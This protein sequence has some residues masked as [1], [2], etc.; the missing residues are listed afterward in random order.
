MFKIRSLISDV[1]M[2]QT[3]SEFPFI[4]ESDK[5]NEIDA[6]LVDTHFLQTMKTQRKRSDLPTDKPVFLVIDKNQSLPDGDTISIKPDSVL[7]LPFT[8]NELK[9]LIQLFN[10]NKVE[11]KTTESCEKST[12]S[13]TGHVSENTPKEMDSSMDYRMLLDNSTVGIYRTTPDGRVLYAN[14]TLIRMLGYSSFQE[15]AQIDINKKY[16]PKYDRKKFIDIIE[17]KGQIVGL[18]EAWERSDGSIIHVRESAKAVRDETGRIL[19]YDGVVEDIT[20]LKSVEKSLSE[21]EE[22][23]GKIFEL[24]PDPIT[25]S[26]IED[27]IFI[28]VNERFCTLT[29]YSKEEVIGRSS[30][31]LGIIPSQADRHRLL[32][33]LADHDFCENI[34]MK[35]QCKDG[36]HIHV[37][38]SCKI[39][40][41]GNKEFLITIH[42]NIEDL[43][44]AE[45]EQEKYIR[46][47]E[48][49]RT[50]LQE[51][52]DSITDGVISLDKN[53]NYIYVNPQAAQMLK[54]T[55][56][57][58]LLGKN[59]WEEFPEDIDGPFY[60]A[61][62]KALKQQQ[63]VEIENYFP[64]WDRWF[65]N[66]IYPNPNGITIYFT[67]TT[68]K[69]KARQK[70]KESE[71]RF[72]SV[73]EHTGTASIIVDFNG[74]ITHANSECYYA[75]GFRPEQLVG[76]PW[77]HYVAPESLDLMKRYFNLRKR[78]ARIIPKR[79]EAK[80]KHA[81]GSVR[82]CLISTG[83]IP[84]QNNMIV[85]MWDITDRVK[86]EEDRKLLATAVEHSDE[87]IFITDKHLKIIYINQRFR[88]LYGYS[89]K[90]IKEKSPK[91]LQ[92]T[93]TDPGIYKNMK[94]AFSHGKTWRGLQYNQTKNGQILEVDVFVSPITNAQGDV[95]HIV[96]IHRD[97]TRE[98]QLE[99]QLQQSQRLEAIGT[100]AGGV[101]HDFNNILT[102]LMG[103]AQMAK[104]SIQEGSKLHTHISKIES[105]AERARELVKQILAFSRKDTEGHKPIDIIPVINDAVKLLKSTLPSTVQLQLKIGHVSSGI[106]ANPTEI[107]QVVINLCTNAYQA[108]NTKGRIDIQL[109]EMAIGDEI[110]ALSPGNYIILKIS[111]NG[112]GIPYE[113]QNRI[114]EPYF[115]TKSEE[116]GTGLGLSIV[117]GIVKSSGGHIALTSTPGKGTTFT[118]YFPAVPLNDLDSGESK[119]I[120]TKGSGVIAVVDDEPDVAELLDQMLLEFG[121]TVISFVSPKEMLKTFKKDSSQFDLIITDTTMPEMTGDVLAKKIRKIRPDI[122]III[123]T[124]YSKRI[125][126]EKATKL[127]NAAF[128]EKPFD[129]QSLM[130]TVRSLL[131]TSE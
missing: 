110:P 59:I 108:M 49:I 20:Q 11:Q 10:R 60:H 24:S 71:E 32:D 72:R 128:M 9:F 94:K 55:A 22:K 120:W 106:I 77:E 34:E 17:S 45:S 95:T 105:A 6:I 79:Y 93:L 12:S 64:P 82:H 33:K 86:I 125:N 42:R 129:A 8:E 57:D 114:F 53:W 112:K 117:H 90:E 65:E 35:V 44:Q 19:Y 43:K 25:I 107:H 7:K 70:L 1:K 131:H 5:S 100:L 50:R 28:D 127:G 99:R 87:A 63:F 119:Q 126:K 118:I 62:F 36:R 39:Y 122:P 40:K 103:Y 26:T 58:E 92:S 78:K 61:C 52:L 75:T 29:G 76:K 81:D 21:S 13:G 104:L 4:T 73:F 121:Y 56:P 96:H 130:K 91:L 46:E 111:D 31:E 89:F 102:P 27:G 3:I 41:F 23:F 67:D 14:K 30:L 83:L 47:I 37:L 113:I 66:R 2:H 16:A 48:I 124:G 88:E 109:S 98:K 18:E 69:N 101:A 116:G 84:E 68:E 85:T 38:T 123:C 51:V 15:L 54:R 115:T 97:V 74:I 80:L